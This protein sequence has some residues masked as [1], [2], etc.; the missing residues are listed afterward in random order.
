MIFR[1]LTRRRTGLQPMSEADEMFFANREQA[2]QEARARRAR[3][4]QTNV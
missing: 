3:K 2:S 1:T 4:E